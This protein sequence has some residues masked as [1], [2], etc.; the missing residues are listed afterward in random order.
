[1]NE[2]VARAAS[3]RAQI[4][5]HDHRYYVLDEPEIP[6]AE[7]DRLMQELRALESAHPELVSSDSPTQRVS[8][9]AAA[10][11]APVAHAVPMLSL[12]NAFSEADVGSF[13]RRVRERLTGGADA[14]AAAQDVPVEYCVEPKLDGLAVSLRYQRGNLAQAATRGDGMTGEDVTA[15]VRTIRSIPLRLAGAPPELLEVRGEVYMPLAGFQ[16]HVLYDQSR[17]DLS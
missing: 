9:A 16:Q 12:D 10:T 13:D 7:Y 17:C 2:A 1:M 5:R 14:A 4:A 3:L 6:D 11:F 15:N 8:G